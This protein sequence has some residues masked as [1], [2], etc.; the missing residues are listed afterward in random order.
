M[1]LINLKLPCVEMLL[2]EKLGSLHINKKG[3]KALQF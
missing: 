3:K 2:N 1:W